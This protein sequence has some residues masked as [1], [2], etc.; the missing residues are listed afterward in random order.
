MMMLA[1]PR[2]Y[3]K[4]VMRPFPIRRGENILPAKNILL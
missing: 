3:Q 1:F 4:F 2:Y